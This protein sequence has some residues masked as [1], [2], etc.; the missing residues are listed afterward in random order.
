MWNGSMMGM[1]LIFIAV[2]CP[3]SLAHPRGDLQKLSA[4]A[5]IEE[6]FLWQ[7]AVDDVDDAAFYLDG[8]LR[9]P[10]NPAGA[11]RGS[12]VVRG[13]AWMFDAPTLKTWSRRSFHPD[14]RLEMVGFRAAR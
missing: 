8:P 13:G 4:F 14:Y 10:R 9:N 12:T 1:R 6:A 2:P 3:Q 5:N 7:R 11:E